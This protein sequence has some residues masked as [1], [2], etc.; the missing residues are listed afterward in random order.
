MFADSA[1][2][3]V[4]R[5]LRV[6]LHVLFATLL[7]VAVLTAAGSGPM[8]AGAG[9]LAVVYLGGTLA[10]QRGIAY[11]RPTATAWL[12]LVLLLWAL[13]VVHAPTFVWL[14]FPLVFVILHVLGARVAGLL[15][16]LLA[17]GWAVGAPTVAGT[18]LWGVGGVIGPAIGTVAAVAIYLVY[19]ALRR[20][21]ER[22]RTIA[23]TLAAT[24][25]SLASSERQAGRLAERERLARDI[26]D[27]LAQGLSS[28]VLISRATR[29]SLAAGEADAA[30]R[31]LGAIEQA[32]SDNL[33]EARQFV[34]GLNSPVLVDS[35]PDALRELGSRA[36]RD[37]AALGHGPSITVAADGSDGDGDGPV[38]DATAGV[39]IRVTQEAITNALK[40]AKASHLVITYGSWPGEI[41]VDVVDDGCG[42]EPTEVTGGY[43]LDGLRA[44][45]E[46]LGGHLNVESVP[47]SGTAVA[48]RL[49]RRTP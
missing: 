3:R 40:H 4:L 37:V 21:A 6:G 26:H 7:C 1:L 14:L 35:L 45:V 25:E 47:G 39:A 48:T 36:R 32:A 38:D 41:T 34:A 28:I 46:E 22:Y 30:A 12:A 11:R 17:W 23:E 9:L 29:K 49:P 24:R 44:R 20:E 13:L 5:W 33:A 8:L 16:V 31:Q 19:R 27:T 42:F 18:Q 43:G 15:V 2:P 10:E